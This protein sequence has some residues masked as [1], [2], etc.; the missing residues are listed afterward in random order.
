MNTL[1][2]KTSKEGGN[3]QFYE[4]KNKYGREQ[5]RYFNFSEIRFKGS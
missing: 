2:Y 1:S 5:K 3:V 4:H